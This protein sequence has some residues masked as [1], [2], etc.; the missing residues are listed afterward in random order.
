M[1]K[2]IKSNLADIPEL[3]LLNDNYVQW[4]EEWA[5]VLKNQ[6]KRSSD[7]IWRGIYKALRNQL[8]EL[9]KE[10]CSFCDDYPVARMSKETIEHYK[11]KSDFPLDAYDWINLFYCCDK[12][13]SEANKIPFVDSLKPDLTSYNFSRY[14]YFDLGSGEIKILE[15]LEIENADAFNRAS[16]FL[17]RYGI[18]NNPA[19]IQARKGLYRDICNHLKNKENDDRV[20]DD[21]CFRYIYDECFKNAVEINNV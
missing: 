3:K 19:R 20:R 12:C 2:I 17:K 8:K 15:N 1:E 13:Q 21:F 5:L 4:G 10:H 6:V 9:T 18:N 7:F 11:P 14:F 16:N